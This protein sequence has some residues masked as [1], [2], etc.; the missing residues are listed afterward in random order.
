MKITKSVAFLCIVAMILPPRGIHAFS[1]GAST[2]RL[3]SPSTK[4]TTTRR[5]QSCFSQYQQQQQQQQQL[6]PFSTS[7]YA[8]GDDDNDNVIINTLE[9]NL[10]WSDRIGC[11]N[12]FTLKE[13]GWQVNVDW[14]PTPYGAG[15]FSKEFIPKGTCIRRGIFGRNLIQFTSITDIDTFC[16]LDPMNENDRR[17]YVKDYLWGFTFSQYTDKEGYAF[18]MDADV[19]DQTGTRRIYAMWIP[20]NGLNHNMIPNTK[21]IE[22][23]DPR[24]IDLV[25]MAD[26]PPDSELFDDYRRH[27]KAPDWLKE[28]AQLYNVT[29]NFAD[30]NDFVET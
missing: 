10:D 9:C 20:G 25:T 3:S 14:R 5:T 29:L 16:K 2:V 4:M 22:S 28:F 13:K 17:E 7:R 8:G 15:L 18:D 24:G 23:K 21:Y 19:Q 12:R 26:V 6:Y 11:Q 1:I 27:G 30:C